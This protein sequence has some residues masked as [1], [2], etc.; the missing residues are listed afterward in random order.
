[1]GDSE[2]NLAD[3]LSFAASNN[4]E[5]SRADPA[6]SRIPV[7]IYGFVFDLLIHPISHESA[8]ASSIFKYQ[9]ERGEVILN[10]R[11]VCRYWEA[12]ISSTPKWWSSLYLPLGPMSDASDG[13]IGC[14]IESHLAKIG[15]RPFELRWDV[16]SDQ[17]AR[18]EQISSLLQPHFRQ[19][20]SLHLAANFTDALVAASQS[21]ISN[22][23]STFASLDRLTLEHSIHGD[24]CCAVALLMLR[25]LLKKS[26]PKRLQLLQGS[27]S[28]WENVRL[29]RFEEDD[30]AKS[31]A[32]TGGLSRLRTL[33]VVNF[34]DPRSLVGLLAFCAET[35]HNLTW[36]L[37]IPDLWSRS[38]GRSIVTL[39]ALQSVVVTG[40]IPPTVLYSFNT[41]SLVHLL[42]APSVP[43]DAQI[44][45]AAAHYAFSPIFLQ[46]LK[47]WLA[48]DPPLPP[49]LAFSL[50]K[51][52]FVVPGVYTADDV[53]ALLHA[54]PRMRRI[55]L[56]ELSDE[57]VGGVDALA[58][59][60]PPPNAPPIRAVL[61]GERLTGDGLVTA[62]KPLLSVLGPPSSSPP[63]RVHFDHSRYLDASDVEGRTTE[64]T[65]MIEKYPQIF[66]PMESESVPISQY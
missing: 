28:L 26:R 59:L 2:S 41:P 56:S 44:N 27:S 35:L 64:L 43:L 10:P 48:P 16:P 38:P 8:L 33:Q 3:S 60:E 15:S 23:V 20:R 54:H 40:N 24:S 31:L 62:L 53:R 47:T 5:A 49:H 13:A 19:C 46:I 14:Y 61:S 18:F 21:Y 57:N 50:E 66:L 34:V 58:S 4:V 52:S 9:K 29:N 65:Q 6:A 36:R 37:D 55:K 32:R 22:G 30:F 51:L 63:F 17:V 11:L 7:E 42:A 25:Y 1:M 12:I 45:A 39:R